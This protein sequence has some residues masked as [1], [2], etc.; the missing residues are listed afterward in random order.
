M[1]NNVLASQRH[2]WDALIKA[3]AHNSAIPAKQAV[4][5]PCGY[6]AN[7]AHS[8]IPA[9]HFVIPASLLV[10]PAK[11]G[12]PLPLA[13]S[14]SQRCAKRALHIRDSGL[15]RNDRKKNRRRFLH[16]LFRRNGEEKM[17]TG[18]CFNQSIL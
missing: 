6:P 1:A 15:R 5:K 9:P 17:R 2:L 8:A 12:I 13:T 4:Q 16:G 18:I 10:I 11:A 7:K 14:A 3:A